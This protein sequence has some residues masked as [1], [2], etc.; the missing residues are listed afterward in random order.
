MKKGRIYTIVFMLIVSA[1]FTLL[2]AGANELFLPKIKENELLA[3]RTAI[4]YVFDID[5]SGTAEEIL[6][7]F[8]ENVSETTL[9]G[10]DVYEYKTA[11]GQP[12]A[13]AVPFSGSGLWGTIAGYM[14]VSAGL[15]KI[16]GV[17]FT[18]Q[19]ETPGLGGRIDELAYREQFRN[20]AIT[21]DTTLAYG[22]N[23]DT[24][25]DAVTGATLTS[26]AVM[27]ILNQ[28]LDETISKLEVAS[29]G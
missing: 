14:G 21:A 7:R 9:S 11:D 25:I 12:I 13:Y 18:D 1:V 27:R 2:L 24:Q 26:N 5:Q 8:D 3:E 20:I 23:G 28:L 15:D 10:V 6:A 29:N 16:T 17:V 4:L 22:Q 19:S